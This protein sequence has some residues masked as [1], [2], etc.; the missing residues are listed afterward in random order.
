MQATP[1]TPL[2]KREELKAQRKL[3]FNRFLRN[4][5]DTPLA[6]KIKSLDDQIAASDEQLE[7]ERGV[8]LNST[9]FPAK[10]AAHRHHGPNS[11]KLESGR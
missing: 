3:L 7:R 8:E 9:G 10:P 6:L 2:R 5:L 1:F 4:P 11:K